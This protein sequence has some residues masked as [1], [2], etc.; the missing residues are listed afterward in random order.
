MVAEGAQMERIEP[1]EFAGQHFVSEAS[2]RADGVVFG[3][4]VADFFAVRQDDFVRHGVAV[5]EVAGDAL[6]VAAFG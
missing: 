1:A 3:V 6:A 5:V 4:L 2:G